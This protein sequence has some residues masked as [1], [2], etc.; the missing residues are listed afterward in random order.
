MSEYSTTGSTPAELRRVQAEL[1]AER[2][3][4]AEDIAAY[5]RAC[6]LAAVAERER[7]EARVTIRAYVESTQSLLAERDSL[8][9]QYDRMVG[10][11][12]K[13]GNERDGLSAE[14]ASA[15]AELD[16][17]RTARD[18]LDRELAENARASWIVARD[19][20]R[21]C[22]RCEQEIR[23]GEAYE[24]MPGVDQL[25]HIHCP[26]EPEERT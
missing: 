24:L 1:D 17:V 16:A 18:N 13:R 5:E 23:R 7:D 6:G 12:I 25:Q 10:A 4:R 15:R 20:G 9:Q 19:G 8:A 14:L 22:V 26:T 3:K 2:D 11:C 21:D